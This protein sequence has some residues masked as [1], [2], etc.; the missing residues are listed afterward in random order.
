MPAHLIKDFSEAFSHFP[1][2]GFVWIEELNAKHRQRN[3]K[4][5]Q[6]IPQRILFG[7]PKTGTVIC[8]PNSFLEAAQA[9][10]PMMGD[11]HQQSAILLEHGTGSLYK[12][13]NDERIHRKS[14]N[15]KEM[16]RIDEEHL[17]GGDV[18]S[19]SGR[20]R[21]KAQIWMPEKALRPPRVPNIVK[22]ESLFEVTETYF[23]P[24][25]NKQYGS[26]CTV[27]VLTE[28]PPPT[29]CHFCCLH[30]DPFRVDD[31]RDRATICIVYGEK[32]QAA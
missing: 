21:L 23:H 1:D 31:V 28:T 15:L 5:V 12:V 24:G 7:Q 25:F 20:E 27:H 18:L 8:G 11:Q 16:L 17:H 19:K 32:R 6:C 30:P 4:V 14:N 9:G 2:T 22:I 10:V 13:L 29:I 3:I 26:A